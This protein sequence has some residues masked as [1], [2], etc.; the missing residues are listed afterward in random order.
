MAR[1][2]E[3]DALYRPL[4]EA[5]EAELAKTKTGRKLLEQARGFGTELAELYESISSG[6]TPYEEGHRLARR[7]REEFAERHDEQFREA[8][9]PHVRLQPSVEAVAQILRPEMS[10]QTAW[11]SETAFLRSTLLQPKPTPEDL[12][13]VRQRLGDPTPQPVQLCLGPP[14][15]WEHAHSQ[16]PLFGDAFAESKLNGRTQIHATCVSTVLVPASAAVVNAWVGDNFAVPAGIKSYAATVDYSFEF[17]G[18]GFALFGVAVAS[19][20]V[21]IKIDKGDGTRI[22]NSAHSICLM[23]VPFV[24][25]DHFRRDG[26]AKVT[27]FFERA[28]STTQIAPGSGTVRVMVG[29]DGHCVAVALIGAAFVIGTVRVHEICVNS[30]V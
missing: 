9:A 20:N 15:T 30:T 4:R 23:T 26:R 3:L 14:Y 18:F 16:A 12:E 11:L 22:D 29:A 7:R 5:G 25:G 21:A 10:S 8:Y 27:V 19:L 17:S 28:G 24:A 6:K 1:G 2:K 13:T